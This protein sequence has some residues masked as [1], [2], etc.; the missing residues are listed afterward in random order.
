[1]TAAVHDLVLALPDGWLVTELT[2]ERLARVLASQGPEVAGVVARVD[3]PTPGG[4]YRTHAERMA[5]RP[6]DDLI[7]TTD[8][9]LVGAVLLRAD[10][11]HEVSDRSVAVGEGRLLIDRGSVAFD[12]WQD[13]GATQD[14]S[15]DGRSPFPYRPVV[16]LLGLGHDALLADWGRS[17][18]NGL[19]RADVEGRLAVPAPTEGLHL[20]VPCL[21][22]AASMRALQPDVL[23]ALDEEAL[24]QAT[25]WLQEAGN[26]STVTMLLTPGTEAEPELVSWRI[27]EARGRLRAR[28][29][30]GT[31]PA[32]LADLVRRLATGPVPVGPLDRPPRPDGQRLLNPR[33]ALNRTPKGPLLSL[34][35][36][37]DTSSP[38][39]IRRFEVI[40]EH[41]APP[42]H[43]S[44]EPLTDPITPGS[45]TADVLVVSDPDVGSATTDLVRARTASGRLTIIDVPADRRPSPSQEDLVRLAGL[46]VTTDDARRDQLVR[47]LG[48]RA[49]T[50]PDLLPGRRASELAPSGEPAARSD[51]SMLGCDV[52]DTSPQVHEAVRD[53][54]VGLIDRSPGLH[55][56]L[57][58]DEPGPLTDLV[59]RAGV[60]LST[61]TARPH[62]QSPWI[63]SIVAA[64]VAPGRR[65][66]G[67]LESQ[68]VGI[69]VI[70]PIDHPA[71]REGLVSPSLVVTEPTDSGSWTRVLDELLEGP[72]IWERRSVDARAL[73]LALYGPASTRALIDRFVGWLRFGAVS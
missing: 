41:F 44:V 32:V 19:I 23:V 1:M 38:E 72:G 13:L 24:D 34:Q 69:P 10:G 47:D 57:V 71:A 39:A 60:T 28:I 26:R 9:E 30:R 63:G 7:A 46:A 40:F 66:L 25:V 36:L 31:R 65:R 14:A 37:V 52:R 11:D 67:L 20:T 56:R 16:L 29:G 18:V 49:F 53:A 3:R 5:T 48:V 8:A 55:L 61:T 6:L 22:S 45:T 62:E 33:R 59:G 58:A 2:R 17:I 12:P 43:T 27:G 54:L 70:C 4:S 50:L 15:P 68:L 73:A 21:P 42:T 51:R 64:H 35:A